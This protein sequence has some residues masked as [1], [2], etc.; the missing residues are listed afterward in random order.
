MNNAWDI[1]LGVIIGA[2]VG[3]IIVLLFWLA[4]RFW[5]KERMV[6]QRMSN[7][8]KDIEEKSVRSAMAIDPERPPSWKVY[9]P[10]K[11]APERTCVCHPDRPLRDGQRVLWW[12]VPKSGGGVNVFCEDGIEVEEQ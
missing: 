9:T 8:R 6:R 3:V 5:Q 4:A 1:Y 2:I 12:P 7:E 11:G 10:R